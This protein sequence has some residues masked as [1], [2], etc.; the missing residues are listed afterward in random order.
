MSRRILVCA[1]GAVIALAVA[2]GAY[3]AGGP[4]MTGP[5]RSIQQ[6]SFTGYYDGHKED[7]T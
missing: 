5:S 7:R 4:I 6:P 2:A 3:A 1:A